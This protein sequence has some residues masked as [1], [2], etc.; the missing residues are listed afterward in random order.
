VRS[1]GLVHLW[2]TGTV[3]GLRLGPKFTTFELVDYEDDSATVRAVL[4]VGVGWIS[5]IVELTLWHRG[6]RDEWVG[7][8][9]ALIGYG[10]ILLHVICSRSSERAM[11]LQ[12]L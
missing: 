12:G 8:V 7:V 11:R 10:T 9:L 3:T 6:S 1:A 5:A 4:P 2:V